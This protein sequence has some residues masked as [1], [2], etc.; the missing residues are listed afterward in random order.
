MNRLNDKVTRW[1]SISAGLLLCSCLPLT[2]QAMNSNDIQYSGKL[3]A[4]PCTVDPLYENFGVDFGGNINSKDLLNGE[5]RYSKEDIQFHLTDC[6][7][8]LGNSIAVKFSGVST[9]ANGLLNVDAGSQASGIAVGLETPSGVA[10][11]INN[12]SVGVLMPITDDEM[13]IRV[14]SYLQA[15]EGARVETMTPG[16]FTATLTYTLM[17]E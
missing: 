7:T 14:R 6:D 1:I 9:T 17:Y 16:F 10:L 4:L 2:A 15:I 8:S 13:T 3:I 5:R 12:V 11:P